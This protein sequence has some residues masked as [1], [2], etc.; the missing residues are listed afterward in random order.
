MVVVMIHHWIG[1]EGELEVDA[2]CD[3]RDLRVTFTTSVGKAQSSLIDWSIPESRETNLKPNKL[4][5]ESVNRLKFKS[6]E[7]NKN[8]N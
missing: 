7:S 1:V 4:N 2:G 5:R 6:R 8:E 3:H